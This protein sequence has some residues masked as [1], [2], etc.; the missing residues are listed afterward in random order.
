M[1]RDGLEGG[2]LQLGHRRR[3]R[4]PRHQEGRV[5]RL[6]LP[7]GHQ[8]LARL[9]P[10]DSASTSSWRVPR[11]QG[12]ELAGGGLQQRRAEAL[13]PRVHRGQEVARPRLEHLLVQHHARG[14]DARHLAA[15]MP[16]PLPGLLHLLAD[17][18]LQPVL[19]ELRDVAARRV[20]RHPAH[21]DPLRALRPRGE[22]DLQELRGAH[23][24]LEEHLVEV[25]EPEE[26]DGVRVE[27]L[28]LE[29]LPHHRSERADLSRP[30][31]LAR[32]LHQRLG[33]VPVSLACLR[34]RHAHRRPSL[35]RPVMD[36]QNT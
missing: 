36:Q 13:G 14:D 25:P 17:G 3:L 28:R 30:R 27:R 20:V 16:G 19:D 6:P 21:R 12:E 4:Q 26:E 11:L 32:R 35:T 24:V 22:G 23:R 29:V 31:G 15:T 34:L 9:A 5:R 18:H 33:L 1:A 2:R 10:R 7:L 8:Q